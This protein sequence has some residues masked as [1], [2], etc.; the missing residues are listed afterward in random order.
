M[1]G[2]L[3][4]FSIP[5]LFVFYIFSVVWPPVFLARGVYDVRGPSL[6]RSVLRSC[7][8]CALFVVLL[9]LVCA[10]GF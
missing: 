8:C 5:V 9:W 2:D 3:L 7:S 6:Y 4:V 1:D 10:P